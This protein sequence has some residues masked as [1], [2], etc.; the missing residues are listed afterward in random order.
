MFDIRKMIGLEGRFL[1]RIHILIPGREEDATQS[2]AVRINDHKRSRLKFIYPSI[3]HLSEEFFWI[4]VDHS[5][6]HKWPCLTL[7]TNIWVKIIF[8]WRRLAPMLPEIWQSIISRYY[9]V[10]I[11]GII[12]SWCSRIHHA[13]FRLCMIIQTEKGSEREFMK[14]RY[15]PQL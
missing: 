14:D 13:S 12:T 4:V 1:R 2:E 8:F 11:V 7:I 15:W 3:Q 5:V 10:W 9:W 6:M